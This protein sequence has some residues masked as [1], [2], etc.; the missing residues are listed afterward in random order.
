[1]QSK[2]LPNPHIEITNQFTIG[3]TGIFIAV[4]IVGIWATSLIF[5]L[6]FDLSKLN[7]LELVL[8]ILGQTFI[9]TGLFITAHDAMHGVVFPKNIKINHLIGTLSL[10]SYGFLSYKTL[11]KKHWLHHHHPASELDPDFH[12]GKHKNFFAWYFYFMKNYWSWGQIITW[13]IVYN[14]VHYILHIPHTNLI[15]FWA[16]PSLLS[17]LQLFYF[18][19]FLTH[20]EPQGGY[21]KPHF[22]QTIS[23]PTWLSL[24]TCYHFGYHKEHHEY[25]HLAWWQLP[26][27]YKLNKLTKTELSISN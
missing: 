7:I 23:M 27:I 3:T 14:S 8:A 19:T 10:F 4:T 22:A 16:L 20:R 18:G 11:L 2:H 1:M 24:I 26:E 13:I 25:P 6:L 17:S 9:Y 15:L 5:L 21:I 12:D